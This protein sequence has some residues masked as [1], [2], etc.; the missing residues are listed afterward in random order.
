MT[1]NCPEIDQLISAIN[2]LADVIAGKT[3]VSPEGNTP[4][5]PVAQSA[6]VPPC[7]VPADPIMPATVPTVHAIPPAVPLA[8]PPAYT[9]DQL[10]RACVGLKDAGKL[11]ELQ[12]LLKQFEV[13]S[14]SELPAERYGDFATAL[15]AMGARI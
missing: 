13:P 15:R 14:M 9:L 8:A 12:A 2:H 10:A 7:A 5:V 6:C 11:P 4:V 1:V 3:T